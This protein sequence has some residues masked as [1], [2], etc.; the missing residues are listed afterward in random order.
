MSSVKLVFFSES[1]QHVSRPAHSLGLVTARRDLKKQGR[2]WSLPYNQWP[3][4]EVAPLARL[5][6]LRIKCLNDGLLSEIYSF[7]TGT[8]CKLTFKMH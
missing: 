7:C 1:V 6:L 4:K 3:E 8:A 5:L 2:I